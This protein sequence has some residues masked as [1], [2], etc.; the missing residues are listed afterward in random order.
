VTPEANPNPFEEWTDIELLDSVHRSVNWLHRLSNSVRNSSVM[1]QDE[2]ARDFRLEDYKGKHPVTEDLVR[3]IYKHRLR[4]IS[5]GL[6]DEMVERLIET[7]VTR[8]KRILYR[9]SRQVK[10]EF[11]QVSLPTSQLELPKPPPQMPSLLIPLPTIITE[12]STPP[13]QSGIQ[14]IPPPP[15]HATTLDVPVWRRSNVR[16]QISRATST[17]MKR[18]D[19]LLVPSPPKDAQKSKSFTCPYCSLILPSST[20][21]DHKNWV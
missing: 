13:S 6:K 11:P 3:V 7:M 2:R 20:A 1:N 17:P 9:R 18:K 14:S 15:K 5:N 16:S 21:Q 8:L 12:S 19:E 10:W 4:G